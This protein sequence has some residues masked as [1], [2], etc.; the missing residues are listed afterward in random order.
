MFLAVHLDD[1]HAAACRGLHAN[2]V[3]LFLQ[4]FLHL[5]KLGKELLQCLDFHGSPFIPA[6]HFGDPAAKPLEHRAHDRVLLEPSA[7]LA[8]GISGANS[9]SQHR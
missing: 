4:I 9:A 1:D 7:Q 8:A 2:A 3:H 6:F 5:P